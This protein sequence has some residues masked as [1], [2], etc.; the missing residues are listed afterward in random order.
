MQNES[1]AFQLIE[2]IAGRIEEH[3]LISTS[4]TKRE[5]N[6]ELMVERNTE[7]VKVQVYF[8][9]KGV[10]TILQGNVDSA[11][12]KEVDKIIADEPKFQFTEKEIDEPNEYI[13][14]DESGKGDFFG[15]LVTAA[16]YINESY[17]KELLSLGVR[18][19][20]DLSDSQIS[21]IASQIK[22][23]F[24]DSHEIITISPPKYNE[25]YEKFKNLNKILN[26]SHS[27]AIE[28]LL[29][30]KDCHY[31]ITD[32]FSKEELQISSSTKMSDVE[33]VQTPKAERFVGVAA[34]SIMAR[35]QFNKWFNGQRKLG[36]KLQKGS[37]EIVEQIARE[38][39]SKFGRDKLSDLAKTHFK[40]TRKLI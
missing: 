22:K 40:T 37:S 34:A 26:W 27:K 31:V 28:N 5:Y 39:I 23:R 15:P 21:F 35:D 29:K 24:P 38:I 9:K 2:K 8:G 18:D 32:K 13:G 36:V 25:L 6:F 1:T 20:K 7:K 19:S 30:K 17:R 16:F 11:L 4:I 12:Y 14:T 3:S 33:F 10:K